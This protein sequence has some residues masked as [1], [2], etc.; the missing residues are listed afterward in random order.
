MNYL[1]KL[2]AG[3]A[4]ALL[5]ISLLFGIVAFLSFFRLDYFTNIISFQQARPFHVS[6][7]LFWIITG[8]AGSILHFKKKEFSETAQNNIFSILLSLPGC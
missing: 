4:L 5:L 3:F 8:A 7:A 6:A 1:Y 2:F